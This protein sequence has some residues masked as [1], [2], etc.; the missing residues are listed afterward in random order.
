MPRTPPAQVAS[1]AAFTGG[2]KEF[3]P[4]TPEDLSNY[5]PDPEALKVPAGYH[6]YETMIVLRASIN[7]QDRCGARRGA[8]ARGSGS[9]QRA[10]AQG[11]LCSGCFERCRRRRRRAG[12]RLLGSL[13]VR[14]RM[15]APRLACCVATR[16]RTCTHPPPASA[17]RINRH[18]RPQGRAAGQV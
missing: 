7:D 2:R 17:A 11:P 15:P 12:R 18:A 3:K 8:R 9:E 4:I 6:W 13:R 5:V 14:G 1:P 10:V 16:T